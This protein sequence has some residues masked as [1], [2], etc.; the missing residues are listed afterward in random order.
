MDTYGEW[1]HVYAWSAN[2]RYTDVS[3]KN[4]LTYTLL[5]SPSLHF[6]T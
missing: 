2:T 6:T 1:I 3:C 4:I 5:K